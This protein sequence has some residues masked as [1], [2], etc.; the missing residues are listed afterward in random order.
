[1]IVADDSVLFREGLV[2]ILSAADFQ[3]VGQVGNVDELFTCLSSA[4]PDLAVLD[5]RMP[6]TH[7]VE[8]LVAACKI[9][10]MHPGLG[11]VVLSQYVE[12]Q[13]LATLIENGVDGL[14]YLLKERVSD[15]DD[16]TEE[17][18]RVAEGGTALDAEVIS[19][20]FGRRRSRAL[21]KALSERER[22][23]LALM[24]EGRSNQA[25]ADRLI[26]STKTV[27]AHISAIFTKLAVPATADDHRRV[28]AVVTYLASC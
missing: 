4:Q 5:I 1:M 21:L 7:S 11:V 3:V 6:P 20:L 22:Q 18:R 9:R 27:E 14:G 28:L 10:A 19:E 17:L 25:I 15:L 23:V 24:A 12:T 13:H 8:G 2:R 26:L 16:F